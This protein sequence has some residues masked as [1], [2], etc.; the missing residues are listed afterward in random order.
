MKINFKLPEVHNRNYP[1]LN[2]YSKI[3]SIYK[4]NCIARHILGKMSINTDDPSA[5]FLEKFTA[6][7]PDFIFPLLSCWR[8]HQSEDHPQ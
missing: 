5:I 8:Q 7:Y 1:K 2:Y 3:I 4:I 6:V